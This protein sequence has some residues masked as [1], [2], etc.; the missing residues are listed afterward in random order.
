MYRFL[1]LFA[2]LIDNQYIISQMG[3]SNDIHQSYL[4]EIQIVGKSSIN[5]YKQ[6]PEVVGTNIYAGRKNSLILLD[7]VL[8]NKSTNTMRQVLA[9]VPGIHIWESDGSGIQIGI[10]S[11]GLSPNR[12]WE[13]N[14]RQNGYDIAADPYGYPEA[15]YNPPMQAVQRLEIVRG[16]ASLQYGPQ[17]GGMINYIMKDGSHLTKR[18][19]FESEQTLGS[20]GLIN[21]FIAIGGHSKKINYYACYDRRQSDGYRENSEYNTDTYLGT[22]TYKL[23]DK[24]TITAEITKW[25]MLSQQPGGLTDHLVYS[26]PKKSFRA[27]NWFH[28]DWLFSALTFSHSWGE[29][30][31]L[32]VKS[33]VMNAE[34]SSIGFNPSSG[35]LVKDTL[36]KNTNSFNPRTLDQDYYNNM[37]IEARLLHD[38]KILGKE[39]TW[40]SGIRWYQGN[41]DRYR[42]GRESGAQSQYT[43]L[44]DETMPWNGIIEYRTTNLAAFTEQVIKWNKRLL[45]IPGV[46]YEYILGTAAGTNGIKDNQPIALVPRSKSRAFLIAGIAAEYHLG[47]IELYGN[48]NQS[49]RPVQFADLTTPPTSDELDPNLKDSKAI[50]IDLGIRGFVTSGL[51]V[52][53]G[54]YNLRYNNRIGTLKRERLDGSFYN[55]RT[56]IGSSKSKGMEMLIEWNIDQSSDEKLC[57]GLIPFLSYSY[58][59]ARFNSL[60]VVSQTG[61]Q[62]AEGTINGNRVENAPKHILRTGVEWRKSKWR[63]IVNYAYTSAMYTDANNTILPSANAQN[64]LIPAYCIADLS[65]QYV[66]SNAIAIK[67]GINNVVNTHYFTRRSGG[68]PGP[69]A[70]PADGRSAWMSVSVRL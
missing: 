26:D 9:K 45:I 63:L 51:R 11:R 68:Y 66:I 52:D 32:V 15:Y 55:L 3:D 30:N 31:K 39:N 25:Q 2:L 57:T 47:N 60:R 56:N 53:I 6:M 29:K 58:N 61:N 16:Q 67:G 23:S 50:N 64:G 62:I 59:D 44:R 49:F 8:G 24:S 7:N 38:R 19:N 70:L 42:G 48:L 14:V 10:A 12:S 28:L 41:T 20:F 5:D 35:I 40:S 65:G 37:G 13:F 54:M 17:I 21:T 1:F 34:R 27:R 69:G 18:F 4:P 36:N 46:R 43:T 22:I 33:F